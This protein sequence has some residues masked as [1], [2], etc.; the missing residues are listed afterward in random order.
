MSVFYIVVLTL[1]FFTGSLKSEKISPNCE[2]KN[3]LVE[4]SGIDNPNNL[5]EA[6]YKSTK[7]T[8]YPSIECVSIIHSQFSYIPHDLFKS[9]EIK[10][11]LIKNTTLT[12]ITETNTA[13]EGL[14]KSLTDLTIANSTLLSDFDWNQLRSLIALKFLTLE[15]IGLE[16]IDNDV[17]AI[18]AGSLIH[19][20]FA[21]NEISFI[22]DRSF[23]PFVHLDGIWLSFNKISNLKRSMF[24]NS[25]NEL[26]KI[27]LNDNK[28]SS[29]PSDFFT[30]M[31]YLSFVDLKNNGF[32]TLDQALFEPI[33]KNLNMIDLSGNPLVCD[34][35]MKWLLKQIFP[36]ITRGICAEP[37]KLLG[38]EIKTLEYLELWCF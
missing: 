3:N 37:S 6:F 27:Y 25:E 19:L 31:P 35:R 24:P 36:I 23:A 15:N 33:W 5:K 26:S 21:N 30:N 9:F 32:I 2:I 29:L 22:K 8:S 4:C 10:M 1:Y 14:E 12:S 11:I 18:A 38:R 28:I 13:F 16:Y 7:D 17:N 34:C 20:S